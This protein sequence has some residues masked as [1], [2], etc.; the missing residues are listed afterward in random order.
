[1]VGRR[2]RKPVT[3]NRSTNEVLV[4]RIRFIQV[5]NLHQTNMNEIIKVFT[6]GTPRIQRNDEAQEKTSRLKQNT[7][8]KTI[9]VGFIT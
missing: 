2:K 6:D 4:G 3:L 1:M 8:R 5:G 7:L 9:G